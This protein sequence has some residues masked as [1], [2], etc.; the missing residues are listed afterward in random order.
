METRKFIWYL[1]LFFA[2]VDV[3]AY[4]VTNANSEGWYLWAI[5]GFGLYSACVFIGKI[6]ETFK[7][8]S[9]S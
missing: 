3:V 9:N 2:A 4:S 1:L 7:P 5:G 6:H 8:K